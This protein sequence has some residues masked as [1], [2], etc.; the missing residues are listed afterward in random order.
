MG[1]PWV[2]C[3]GTNQRLCGYVPQAVLRK[4]TWRSATGLIGD[5]CIKRLLLLVD[6]KS[7][8]NATGP[9]APCDGFPYH[10]RIAPVAEA[11]LC[12]LVVLIAVGRVLLYKQKRMFHV[13]SP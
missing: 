7:S 2:L 10:G 8:G 1:C 5:R 9:L 4:G 13:V 3:P 11:H 12:A 6:V